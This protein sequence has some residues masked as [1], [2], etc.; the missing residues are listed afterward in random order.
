[1]GQQR[2]LLATA[3]PLKLQCRILSAMVE[4]RGVGIILFSQ[5]AYIMGC[6][7][8]LH[9]EIRMEQPNFLARELDNI[10]EWALSNVGTGSFMFTWSKLDSN[11][12]ELMRDEA[13]ILFGLDL[14]LQSESSGLCWDFPKSQ[15]SSDGSG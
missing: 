8:H 6:N 12:T 15:Y 1:M 9:C 5:P 10:I 13:V 4:M 11:S 7:T 14:L 2:P 3:S